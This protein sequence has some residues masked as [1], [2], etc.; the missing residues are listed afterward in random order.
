MLHCANDTSLV[1]YLQKLTPIIR[2]IHLVVINNHNWASVSE[3]HTSRKC[4]SGWMVMDGLPDY[5]DV[6]PRAHVHVLKERACNICRLQNCVSKIHQQ[7]D[8]HLCK[9]PVNNITL[10]VSGWNILPVNVFLATAHIETV[11]SPLV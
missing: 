1:L 4:V 5:R 11:T 8:A 10:D 6:I 9:R 3:P 2:Y 7:A